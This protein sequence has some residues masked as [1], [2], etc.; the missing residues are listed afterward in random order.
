MEHLSQAC[1]P[2]FKVI[3]S[4]VDILIISLGSF[5]WAISSCCTCAHT[6]SVYTPFLIVYV[7]V[8]T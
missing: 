7:M 4:W 1:D 3:P 2:L 5:F 6:R 8:I